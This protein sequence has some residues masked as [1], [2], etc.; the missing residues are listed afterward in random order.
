MF[1][2]FDS[3]DQI[4]DYFLGK[5]QFTCFQEVGGVSYLHMDQV[6]HGM[7]CKVYWLSYFSFHTRAVGREVQ[8]HYVPGLLSSFDPGRCIESLHL[9][10]RATISVH[11]GVRPSCSFLF[12]A[13]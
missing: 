1:W 11:Y 7:V 2:G 13:R 4:N 12:G 3:I 8:Q 10:V 6:H 9:Q 5:R